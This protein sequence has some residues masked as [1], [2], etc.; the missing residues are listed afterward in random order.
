LWIKKKRFSTLKI[1]FV[2]E[3]EMAI[4][5]GRPGQRQAKGCE[6]KEQD[7]GAEATH[8]RKSL[9]QRKR[10]GLIGPGAIVID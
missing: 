2:D 7:D 1:A 3:G 6:K 8:P 9:G 4:I 5:L 10:S